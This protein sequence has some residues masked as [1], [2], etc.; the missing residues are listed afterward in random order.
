VIRKGHVEAE[1]SSQTTRKWWRCQ[2]MY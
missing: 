1:Q 2:S